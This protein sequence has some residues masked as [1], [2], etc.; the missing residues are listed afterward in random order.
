MQPSWSKRKGWI[1]QARFCMR[2]TFCMLL[3]RPRRAQQLAIYVGWLSSQK[4]GRHVAGAFFVHPVD[5]YSWILSF[6]YAAPTAT[7]RGIAAIFLRT[8]T[9][10]DRNRLDGGHSHRPK[11]AENEVMWALGL[12]WLSL[13]SIFSK[14]HFPAIVSAPGIIGFLGGLR[15][16]SKFRTAV[17]KS[18]PDRPCL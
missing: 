3:P 2:L 18:I 1:S 11:I 7:S 9:C 12:R 17:R 6:I 4:R 13:R 5:F 16:K 10:R 8:Q 15:W 14:R